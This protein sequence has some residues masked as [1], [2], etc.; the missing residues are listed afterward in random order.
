MCSFAE[1][2]PEKLASDDISIGEPLQI[3]LHSGKEVLSAEKGSETTDSN[4]SPREELIPQNRITTESEDKKDKKK[5]NLSETVTVLSNGQE[6]T[7]DNCDQ[8][9]S[10]IMTGKMTWTGDL[11]NDQLLRPEK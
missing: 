9:K 3:P 11:E 1:E 7:D 2:F 4:F 6:K 5:K 8:K 10:E